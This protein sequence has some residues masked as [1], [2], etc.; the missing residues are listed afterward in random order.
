MTARQ[1][2]TR[3]RNLE[4]GRRKALAAR[5]RKAKQRE[6]E[7]ARR[8]ERVTGDKLSARQPR[9]AWRGFPSIDTLC[10]ALVHEHAPE[11]SVV[12]VI[13]AWAGMLA[14]GKPGDA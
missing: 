6:A 1:E 4:R 3:R 13:A 9:V 5:R 14:T 2:D 7:R 8:I 12:P 10:L 11:H